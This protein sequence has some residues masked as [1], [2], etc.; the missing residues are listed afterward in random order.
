MKS[1][2]QN[3]KE[4]NPSTE[5]EVIPS[6]NV[7]TCIDFE[8]TGQVCKHC[9]AVQ[10][11]RTSQIAAALTAAKISALNRIGRVGEVAKEVVLTS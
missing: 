8:R 10:I 11:Y 7:C 1:Q 9:I 5:Y 3:Q 2:S 6:L 4:K